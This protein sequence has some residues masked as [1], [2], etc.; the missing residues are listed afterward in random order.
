MLRNP[1]FLKE[2]GVIGGYVQQ[3]IEEII[4]S[5]NNTEITKR[6]KQLLKQK[7]KLIDEPLMRNALEREYNSRFDNSY[8]IESEIARLNAEIRRLKAKKKNVAFGSKQ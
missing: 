6:E 4:K 5:L 2:K 8:D 1:F 7:I 3:I